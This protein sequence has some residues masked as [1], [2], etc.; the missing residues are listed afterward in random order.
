MTA[1]LDGL[2]PR[3]L[4]ERLSV[5]L[6][7]I[8]DAAE[9]RKAWRLRCADELGVDPR[10]FE[11]WEYGESAVSGDNLLK[12][13][14]YFG[15]E[16]ANEVLSLAGYVAAPEGTMGHVPDALA[17]EQARRAVAVLRAQIDTLGGALGLDN[18]TAPAKEPA[19]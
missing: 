15:P 19:S 2:S 6:R 5:A 3:A 17:A 1:A 7:R 12:L 13:F 16:L 10:T 14:A 11:K 4:S 8:S 9:S 18:L